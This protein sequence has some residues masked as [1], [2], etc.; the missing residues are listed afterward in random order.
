MSTKTDTATPSRFREAV[1]GMPQPPEAKFS[2]SLVFVECVLND[3]L[4]SL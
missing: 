2:V 3:C 1:F 4:V